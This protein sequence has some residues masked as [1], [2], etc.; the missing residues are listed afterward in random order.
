MSRR[1]YQ[2]SSSFSMLKVDK[3]LR[4]WILHEHEQ[5]ICHIQKKIL[6]LLLRYGIGN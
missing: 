4:I 6:A 1:T 3:Q 5:I 2:P